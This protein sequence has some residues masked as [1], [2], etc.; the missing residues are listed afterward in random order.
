MAWVLS[1]QTALLV[2]LGAAALLR[3]RGGRRPGAPLRGL[4]APV[5]A[6][7]ASG[8]AVAFSADLVYRVADLLDLNVSTAHRLATGP[9][10]TY[11][12]AIFG[13]FLAVVAALIV[14]GLTTLVSRRAR[15]RTAGAIVARDFPD[16]PPEAAP[17]LHQVR[18]AIARARFT[19][20]LEPLTV[21]YA[22]LLALG[23]ATSTLGL[24]QLHP[25][26]MIDRYAGIPV[27]L[28]TFLVGMGSYVIAAVLLG[29]VIGGIFAYRTAEFRRYVG[30]LWDLGTFWPRAA[31][32]FAPPCYANGPCPS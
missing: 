4:G 2:A 8:L 25:H 7:V 22:V 1:T 3:R 31:H 12:W 24:L 27:D 17:R 14:A 16:A 11:T 32:P 15:L 30:V 29:L 19:E 10:L 13:F 6:A 9:P 20:R 18:K 5:I 21:A 23:L 26:E 28:V